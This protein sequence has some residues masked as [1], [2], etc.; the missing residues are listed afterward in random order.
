LISNDSILHRYALAFPA[1]HS[2]TFWAL[3][4]FVN[5][6]SPTPALGIGQIIVELKEVLS[7]KAVVVR[8]AVNFS[9]EE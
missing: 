1:P 7:M 8:E 6:P 3:S 2:D 9:V 4:H 5:L